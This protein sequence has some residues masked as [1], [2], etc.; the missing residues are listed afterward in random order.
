MV[1][2]ATWLDIREAVLA[3]WVLAND[4]RW[5]HPVVAEKALESW[6]KMRN[7][8]TKKRKFS[9]RQSQRS[10][11]RWSRERAG[12]PDASRDADGNA[13][14]IANKKESDKEGDSDT[15]NLPSS[16]ELSGSV[17]AIA[18]DHHGSHSDY[19]ADFEE[20]WARYP[21]KKG[22]ADAYRAFTVARRKIGIDGLHKGFDSYMA[23]RLN[24]PDTPHPRAA[25]WLIE[26]RW[27]DG[28]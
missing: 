4:G 12:T 3:P 10:K 26:Q 24:W 15:E 9:E 27:E 21:V 25:T 2:Y 16:Y 6:G 7:R 1:D 23:Y 8:E 19:P 5:Y 11:V 14:R 22:K 13:G 20:W 18:R 17:A 28:T